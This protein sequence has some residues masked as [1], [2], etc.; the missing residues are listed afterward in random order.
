[1]QT[2]YTIHSSE[3]IPVRVLVSTS[4]HDDGRT[5]TVTK[6]NCDFSWKEQLDTKISYNKILRK[7]PWYVLED[8]EKRF[9]RILR[10]NLS[11]NYNWQ[12]EVYYPFSDD[13]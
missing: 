9:H 6:V 10:K 11:N 3:G 8:P 4:M 2:A 12:F 13:L 5:V 7:S 1:M